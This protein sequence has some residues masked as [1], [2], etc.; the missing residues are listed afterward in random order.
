MI[1]G[2]G[3]W[4][5]NPPTR[6]VVEEAEDE[7]AKEAE[8]A[9]SAWSRGEIMHQIFSREMIIVLGA[10]VAALAVLAASEVG[11]VAYLREHHQ[12]SLSSLVFI[13]WSA[14]SI[15]GGLVLG[16]RRRPVP[17]F[18]VLLGLGLLTIPVGMAPSGWW[19]LVAILP[20]GFFCAP[21]LTA[22]AA[23]VS[24]LVP[25][26]IRGEAMGWYGTAITIGL[27]AGAP[28]AGWAIDRW[29]PWAGFALI[30]TIGVVVAVVGLVLVPWG[31]DRPD[32]AGSGAPSGV[33][34]TR[35]LRSVA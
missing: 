15:V 23:A 7:L 26:R 33:S 31:I 3:L 24:R 18:G 30:G 10:T 6:T 22:T 2:T 14:S 35:R 16:A 11:V 17:V 5:F 19:L 4:L 13:L 29:G 8:K 28:L 9:E 21:S 1:A 20:T 27:A 25:E 32:S 34:P 12:Q